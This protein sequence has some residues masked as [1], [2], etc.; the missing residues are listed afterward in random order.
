MG[1]KTE[2]EEYQRDAS[3]MVV[4]DIFLHSLGKQAERQID[5]QTHTHT[6]TH[7]KKRTRP[8]KAL[9]LAR[10]FIAYRVS[11]GGGGK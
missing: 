5:R 10:L 7:E 2:R 6:R 8:R 11:V 4:V 3:T 1:R 9:L